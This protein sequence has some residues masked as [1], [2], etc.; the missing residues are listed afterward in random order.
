MLAVIPASAQTASVARLD[1]AEGGSRVSIPDPSGVVT[2]EAETV[3]AGFTPPASGESPCNWLP[4]LSVGDDLSDAVLLSS[5][6]GFSQLSRATLLDERVSLS[7]GARAYSATGRWWWRSCPNNNGGFDSALIPEGEAVTIEELILRSLGVLDPPE[8]EVTVNPEGKQVVQFRSLFWVEPAYWN[9][10][11]SDTQTAGRVV[12]T[13]VLVPTNS[14][15][16]PG[17]GSFP[18]ECDGPGEIW[19]RGMDGDTFDCS[20]TYRTVKGQPFPFTATVQFEIE[21]TATVGGASAPGNLG[22]YEFLERTTEF[23]LGVRE[24]QIVETNG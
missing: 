9:A 14:V 20:H 18:V 1:D 22:P 13:V 3:A 24:I 7:G 21:V 16:D 17:D 5:V 4:E 15:W 8:P 6:G 23:D 11:R 10:T 12:S 2:N 19:E